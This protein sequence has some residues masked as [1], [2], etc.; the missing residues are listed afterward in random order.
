MTGFMTDRFTAEMHIRVPAGHA[1][2]RQRR[3]G[4]ATSR[5]ASPTASPATEYDFNWTKPGF[6]GTVIA[7]RFRR[8][9]SPPA[10]ATSR[11]TSP[12]ATR[13]SANQLAQTAAERVRLLHRQLRPARVQPPQRRRDPRR[14]PARRLGAR[15][16]P[17]SPAPASATNPASACS[18]TPSPTSG[19]APRSAPTPSTTPGSPTACPATA[20]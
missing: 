10:P 15:D 16:S 7:G 3:A 13:P 5:H 4:A 9:P 18:P 11:S 14:H 1:R 6:P 19:G 17:P 20:S 2:L 12:S 8:P